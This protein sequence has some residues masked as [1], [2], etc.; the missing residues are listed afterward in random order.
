MFVDRIFL[1]LI[2]LSAPYPWRQEYLKIVSKTEIVHYADKAACGGKDGYSL[3]TGIIGICGHGISDFP[4]YRRLL[5]HEMQHRLFYHESWDWPNVSDLDANHWGKF[6]HLCVR[7][8]CLPGEDYNQIL[9]SLSKRV[10]GDDAHLILELHAALP[11]LTKGKIPP[12][13]HPW[14]PWFDLSTSSG[15]P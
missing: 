15:Q 6:A 8:F 3:D 7:S 9:C 11:E 10:I 13:L 14:Y 12:V 4:T 5:L 1:L 2:L